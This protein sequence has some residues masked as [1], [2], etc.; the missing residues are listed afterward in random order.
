MAVQVVFTGRLGLHLTGRLG[1]FMGLRIC[2]VDFLW[3]SLSV[4]VLSF[5]SFSVHAC[6]FIC[7]ASLFLVKFLLVIIVL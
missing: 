4:L 1:E 7:S 2:D 3:T 6:V 5:C